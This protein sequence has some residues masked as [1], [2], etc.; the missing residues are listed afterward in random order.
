MFHAAM[1]KPKSRRNNRQH[2]SNLQNRQRDLHAPAQPHTQIIDKSKKRDRR[3][4]QRLRP[5]EFEIVRFGRDGINKVPRKNRRRN[6]RNQKT[7]KS[8]EPRRNGRRRARLTH[9]RM[10]PPKKKS[11]HRPK[12]FAQISILPARFRQRRAQLRKRQRPK[13]RKQPA[14]D[15]RGIDDA[16]RSAHR[17]HLARLQKNPRAHHRPNHNGRRGPRPQRAYQ[18]Q[19]FTILCRHS[20]KI[21]LAAQKLI[22]QAYASNISRSARQL[23]HN[24]THR[25]RHHRPRQHVPRPSQR[26]K[27]A[28]RDHRSKPHRKSRER[29]SFIRARVP[30][31]QQKHAQQSPIRDGRNRQPCHQHRPPRYQRQQSQH[32]APNQSHLPRTP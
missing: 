21:P 13:K 29:S 17:R 14:H 25:K 26:R 11:P 3:H 4:R 20:E 18:V 6:H 8:R 28:H 24:R 15:P 16:H 7:R 12:P 27:Q 5:S 30:G 23:A 19:P 1:P 22:R 9:R 31:A 2:R 32:D 10:H